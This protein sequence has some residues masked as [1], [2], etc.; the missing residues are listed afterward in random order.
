MIS[1]DEFKISLD[2]FINDLLEDKDTEA[3]GSY[4]VQNYSKRSEVWY[5]VIV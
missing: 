3:F 1:I 5:I 4:F 2:Q